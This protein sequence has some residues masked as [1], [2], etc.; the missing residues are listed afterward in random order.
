MEAHLNVYSARSYP[1]YTIL[2]PPVTG[3]IQSNTDP[4]TEP[5]L[6]RVRRRVCPS[7]PALQ[8]PGGAPQGAVRGQ[9]VH[10]QGVPKR[11]HDISTA[12]GAHEEP[13]PDEVRQP[14]VA[15]EGVVIVVTRQQS[16]GFL[17]IIQGSGSLRS[18]GLSWI[19][20]AQNTPVLSRIALECQYNGKEEV[21]ACIN[22]TLG[23]LI[24]IN[25]ANLADITCKVRNIL[26]IVESLKVGS[27]GV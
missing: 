12:E 6:R 24:C 7:E 25:G 17:V 22:A 20:T 19:H 16:Q 3:P 1:L 5:D 21:Q 11:V 14:A 4:P 26:N 23:S 10:L 9:G 8:P 18:H 2:L 15:A 27:M 13:R